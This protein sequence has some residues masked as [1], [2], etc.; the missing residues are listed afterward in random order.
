MSIA[1]KNNGSTN[2]NYKIIAQEQS[3]LATRL[4]QNRRFRF[5]YLSRFA[6]FYNSVPELFPE[7][8]FGHI[9]H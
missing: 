7:F 3:A 2:K 6:K 5:Q 4:V 9:K 1:F 8:S